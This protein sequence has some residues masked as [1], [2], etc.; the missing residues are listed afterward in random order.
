MI[1]TLTGHKAQLSEAHAAIRQLSEERNA[2]AADVQV[3]P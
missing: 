2:L 1:N 3:Y